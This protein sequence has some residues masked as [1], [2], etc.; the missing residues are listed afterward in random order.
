[1]HTLLWPQTIFTL[2]PKRE[3][4]QFGFAENKIFRFISGVMVFSAAHFPLYLVLT[5]AFWIGL[6]FALSVI[7]FIF[8]LV[9]PD[10]YYRALLVA[11]S[12]A[13]YAVPLVVVGP[14]GDYRYVYWAA[15]ATC[16]AVLLAPQKVLVLPS[17]RA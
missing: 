13:F 10:A 8:Y 14:G 4:F 3:S 1:M 5:D 16:I 9:R 15:G 17:R 2:E 7:L 6:S 12:A 11:L